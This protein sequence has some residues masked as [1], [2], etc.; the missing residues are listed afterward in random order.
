MPRYERP[1]VLL[2]YATFVLIGI[3][4]GG[5]GV[6]LLAQMGSYGV[7]RA[8]IGIIFFTGSVGFVLAGFHNGSLIHRLGVRVAL[9][10]GGG[11]YVLAGLYLAT[12]PPFAAFVLVQVVLGYASGVLESVLNTYLASLPD[13]RALLNQLHA[14]FGVGALLGPVVASWIVGFAPWTLVYLVLAVAYL[15][16]VIGFLVSYPRRQATGS[17]APL[18]GPPAP[19]PGPVVPLFEPVVALS[20][21]PAAPAES[22]APRRDGGLL[23]AALRERGVLLGAAFLA[24]Y[25]GLEIGM[26][27]WGFS[28]LVEARGL[29]SSLAG[30]SVSGYWLGLTVGRFLISPIAARIGATTA[31]MMYACL[32]GVAAATTLAWLSP[33]AILASVALMLLGFFLGPIFPTTMAIVPQ[34]TEERLTPAAIGVLNA[35]S[36]VGGSALPWLAGAISQ[37]TGIWTLLPFT[38]ALGALQFAAWRPLAR[39]IGT[40]RVGDEQLSRGLLRGNYACRGQA[41]WVRGNGR[42]WHSTTPIPLPG[43]GCPPR[44]D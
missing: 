4:A 19:L 26:G 6:L 28:Y 38:L 2:A 16:L 3:A 23:G 36:T 9:A 40:P 13:A 42:G 25:V 41:P 29:S 32:I 43:R 22:P 31:S 35:G 1:R 14:F 7:D 33:L 24:I 10:V 12:R 18:P 39:R 20:E 11:A 21:S 5:N 37:A 30:Y 27:N 17:L 44:G 15:P 34:L 8:T